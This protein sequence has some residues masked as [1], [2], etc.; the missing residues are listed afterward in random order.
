MPL[1][2]VAFPLRQ[3]QPAYSFD[4]LPVE[5]LRNHSVEHDAPANWNI[6]LY[7]DRLIWSF[8]SWAKG[9]LL[10]RGRAGERNK[11]DCFKLLE[12]MVT[13]NP[14]GDSIFKSIQI[15]FKQIADTW[16]SNSRP[17]ALIQSWQSR[18]F[19]RTAAVGASIVY[20]LVHYGIFPSLA[21]IVPSRS[22]AKI[23]SSMRFYFFSFNLKASSHSNTSSTVTI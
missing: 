17:S 11:R 2:D 3:T 15:T 13:E 23:E 6:A 16:I 8:W 22:V 19:G 14:I 18:L 10:A 12:R 5:C 9:L 4:N 20:C 21:C 7:Y 1:G